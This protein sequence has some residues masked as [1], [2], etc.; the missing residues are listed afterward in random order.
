MTNTKSSGYWQEFVGDAFTFPG[1]QPGAVA[2]LIERNKA[3]V[4]EYGYDSETTKRL[5]SSLIIL[6]DVVASKIHDDP[7][8]KKL[9]TVLTHVISLSN[10]SYRKVVTTR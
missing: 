4:Q 1:W 6:D 2:R 5:A 3:I 7:M 10:V 9:A 8:F